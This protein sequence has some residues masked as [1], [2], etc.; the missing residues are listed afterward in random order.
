MTEREKLIE[1]V[2]RE[3]RTNGIILFADQISSSLLSTIERAGYV[4][5]R[6]QPQAW[7]CTVDGKVQIPCGFITDNTAYRDAHKGCNWM[8][9][10][11]ALE[12]E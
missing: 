12:A 6:K 4:V 11:R 3:L 7:Y 1:A 5:C 10:Y 8:P 9:L 2:T